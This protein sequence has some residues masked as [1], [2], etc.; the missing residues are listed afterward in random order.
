M[1]IFSEDHPCHGMSC[2]NCIT[3][4]FDEPILDNNPLLPRCNE[5]GYLV[6]KYMVGGT[7]SYNAACAKHMIITEGVK[8]ERII[9]RNVSGTNAVIY[10]PDWCPKILEGAGAIK[11][12]LALPP[13]KSNPCSYD[14][15]MEKRNKMKEL[16]SVMDWKAIK[17]GDICVVPRL[18]RQKRK[19]LLVKEASEYVIKCI[20]LDENL[21]PQSRVVNLYSNDIDINFI[22]KYHKF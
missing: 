4:K 14:D 9:Q 1:E 12:V 3:C 20:E 18:L 21:E 5:C 2:E 16:P 10:A 8:R 19:I 15:Y 11:P 22:V 13:P 17:E 7:I 6:K